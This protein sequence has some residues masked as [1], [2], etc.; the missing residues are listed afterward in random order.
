MMQFKKR[1][2]YLSLL[3]ALAS[4]AEAALD[5]APAALATSMNVTQGFVRVPIPG[6]KNTA[7]FFS[8]NNTGKKAKSL[9]AITTKVAQRAEIH[10]HTMNNGIM[11]MRQVEQVSIVAGAT[12]DFAPGGLH[13]MLF[14]V[15]RTLRTGDTIALTL[16]FADKTQ[17]PIKIPV[18]S[19]YD[20]SHH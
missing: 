11:R 15:Q 1:F 20:H 16:I 13:I 17:L 2:C 9:V 12:T 10:S 5:A 7:A 8:L 6:Q 18:K 3:F 4:Y 14:D 19:L